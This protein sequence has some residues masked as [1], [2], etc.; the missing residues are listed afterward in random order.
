MERGL[1]KHRRITM[2]MTPRNPSHFIELLNKPDNLS[3]FGHINETD[4][5]SGFVKTNESVHVIFINKHVL[6][7]TRQNGKPLSANIDE[8]FSVTPRIFYQL[9]VI[10]VSWEGRVC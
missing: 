2:P 1:Q 10:L 4:F 3:R 7:I 9:L 6:N 8:T 5:Y